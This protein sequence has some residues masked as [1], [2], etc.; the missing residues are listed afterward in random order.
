MVVSLPASRAPTSFS[1]QGLVIPLLL[2][3]ACCAAGLG[4]IR[5]GDR[6]RFLH[7]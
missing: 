5:R 2:A 3:L 6:G 1:R 7:D 4:V